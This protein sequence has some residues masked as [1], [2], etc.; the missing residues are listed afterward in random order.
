MVEM[1]EAVAVAAAVGGA[2]C[3]CCQRETDEGWQTGV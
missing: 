3:C 1:G 2:G